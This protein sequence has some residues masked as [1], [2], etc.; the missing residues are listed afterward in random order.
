MTEKEILDKLTATALHVSKSSYNA[1]D[2]HCVGVH[3]LYEESVKMAESISYHAVKGKFPE[4]LFAHRSPNQTDKEADY[5]KANYKQYTLPEY[6]DYLNTITRP[7]GDGNWSIDY[8]EEENAFVKAGK[9]FQSYVEK[10]LPIYGSLETAMKS[11]IPNLKSIDANGFLAVRPKEIEYV[12]NDKDEF[13]IDSLEPPKPT[14]YFFDSKN[15]IDYKE[16]EYYLFLSKEKS[17][18]KFGNKYEKTGNV[19]EIYTK[20]KVFF[21]KQVGIK[22]ENT[23]SLE[24]FF[25]H[26][27]NECPV[28]QLKGIPKLEGDEILWQ[29]PFIFGCDLLDCVTVNLNW[30]QFITNKCVF[31]MTVMLGSPCEFQNS[32]GN[33]CEGGYIA[34]KEGHRNICK[35]CNGVGT[36]GR[37][38]PL[39]TLLINPA[40]KFEEGETKSTQA[41]LSYVAPPVETLEFIDRKSESDRQKARQILHLHTSNSQVKGSEDMTATGMVLDNKAMTAF[42]KPVI[43]QIFDTY[44]FL[45]NTIGWQRYRESF[46]EPDLTYP[47]SYDF[48]SPEDY[49]NDLTTAIEKGLPPAYIQTLLFQYINSY[50][51]DNAKTTAIFKLVIAADRLFGLSQDE[52]NMK[53]ARGT[54]AKWEDILHSSALSFVNDEM[55]ADPKFIENDKTTQ[56]AR[57][58]EIAKQKESDI[59]GIQSDITKDILP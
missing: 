16:G 22:N 30:L 21:Y 34:D 20:D 3:D 9:S 41:P 1:K 25:V 18:V 29:S 50:Y 43:D 37:L 28:T 48:K 40:S 12:L 52:I 45:L 53:L 58:V 33:S 46:K 15:V 26:D 4:K 31:P 11:I 14:I 59:K 39:G 7:F 56:I 8:R 24:L 55:S 42:V 51:G 49:L 6:V 32:E 36:V 10:E 54:V 23:F 35:N 47:K 19:F 2:K 44:L 57:L 17:E 27:A 38:S 5:I 13:V